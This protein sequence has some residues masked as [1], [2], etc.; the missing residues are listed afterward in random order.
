MEA[1]QTLANVAAAYL[2]NARAREEAHASSDQMRHVATHDPLTGLPNRMLLLQRIEHAA[3]RARRSHSPAGVL[4]VDLDRFKRVNDTY[5]HETG[6]E[7]LKAVGLRLSSVIRPGDT[8]ARVYGDEFVLLC[9]D[10]DDEGDVNAVA[11]RFSRAFD[12][13]F[14]VL[15]QKV[16]VSASVG[17]A[18]AGPGDQISGALVADAD[19]AMYAVKRQ[20][21]TRRQGTTSDALPTQAH[22]VALSTDLRDALVGGDLDVAY[23]PIVGSADGVVS[24]VEV[25]LRW[26]HPVEGAIDPRSLVAVAERTGI[27]DELGAWVLERGC[28]DR[29]LWQRSHPESCFDLAVN[30]STLQI[31]APGFVDEVSATLTRTG[32]PANRLVLEVTESVLIE[33]PDRARHVLRELQDREIR[34]ALDDFGSGY[35]SLSYL[36]RLPIDILKIDRDAITES[37]GLLRTRDVIAALTSLAHALEL[38]VVIEGV[39]TH[40]QRVEAEDVGAD[41]SQG[42]YYARP[43]PAGDVDTIMQRSSW[44]LA[45]RLPL[46]RPP[47][48]EPLSR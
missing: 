28:R 14:T 32:M 46:Q 12:E 27:M 25:L 33:D 2:L 1:A 16:K 4:F 19:Q 18:Y 17:V 11:E 38:T 34:I 37:A 26:A 48:H 20:G 45:L 29:M 44:A 42:Y 36:D 24:A 43:M 8:L 35:S 31:M 40:S 23:Q 22:S 3:R 6:D 7:L 13:P 47:R 41:L 15:D 5:G 30:I 21:A 9:E 10:L 39:E